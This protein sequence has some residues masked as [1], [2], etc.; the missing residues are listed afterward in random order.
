MEFVDQAE[1][2]LTEPAKILVFDVQG[3][4]VAQEAFNTAADL[5]WRGYRSDGQKA[6][7]GIYFVR[8]VQHSKQWTG[9]LVVAK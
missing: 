7:P 8:V 9:K 4:M 1:I 3:R 2:L 6:A 5:N